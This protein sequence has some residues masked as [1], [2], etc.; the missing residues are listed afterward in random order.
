MIRGFTPEYPKTLFRQADLVSWEALYND[1]S[2]HFEHQGAKYGQIDR[3]RLEEFRLLKGGELLFA[4]WPP[5]GA[6]GRN[7]VYR[8]RTGLAAGRRR[9]WFVVGWYPMGPVTAI[10]PDEAEYRTV[11]AFGDHPDLAMPALRPHEGELSDDLL[12]RSP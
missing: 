4:A 12:S 6:S 3:S 5:P 1:G 9:V 2:M 7:L 10:Y 8:R 11:Q